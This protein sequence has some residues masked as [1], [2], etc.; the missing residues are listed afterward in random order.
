MTIADVTTPTHNN[1]RS[2]RKLFRMAIA[3]LLFSLLLFH[4]LCMLS[5]PHARRGR[6]ITMSNVRATAAMR[7]PT[8]AE[9]NPQRSGRLTVRSLLQDL[10]QWV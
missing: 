2:P 4:S 5:P 7:K 10:P 9:A 1:K 6:A 3:F 8:G